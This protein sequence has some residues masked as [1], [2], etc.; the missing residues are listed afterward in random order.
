M[1]KRFLV[2][3]AALFLLVVLA[4]ANSDIFSITLYGLTFTLTTIMVGVAL[5][6]LCIVLALGLLAC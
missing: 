4:V 3:I 2:L 5:F 1:I 6:F